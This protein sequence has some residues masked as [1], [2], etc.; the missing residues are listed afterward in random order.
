MILPHTLETSRVQA[1]K[2][3]YSVRGH[4]GGVAR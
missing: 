4:N 2:M 1:G 3:F